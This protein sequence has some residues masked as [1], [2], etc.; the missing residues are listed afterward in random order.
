MRWLVLVAMVGAGLFLGPL[1]I[2][3]WAALLFSAVVAASLLSVASSVLHRVR[4]T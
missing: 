1:L 3:L 4:G 2:M